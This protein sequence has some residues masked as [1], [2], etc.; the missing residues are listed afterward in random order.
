[1]MNDELEDESS[2][3]LIPH[4]SFHIHHSAI[5]IAFPCLIDGRVGAIMWA[6]QKVTPHAS[7]EARV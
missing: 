3:L 5:G 6:E 4:S 7:F 1:M 2:F